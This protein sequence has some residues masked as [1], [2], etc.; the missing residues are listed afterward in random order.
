MVKESEMD[1]RPLSLYFLSYLF[2][3]CIIIGGVNAN[4]IVINPNTYTFKFTQVRYTIFFLYQLFSEY[5][6]FS[7]AFYVHLTYLLFVM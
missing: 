1:S 6:T 5:N 4:Q 2:V 7:I 3:L